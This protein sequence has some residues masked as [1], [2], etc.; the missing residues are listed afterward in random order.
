MYRITELHDEFGSYVLEAGDSRVQIMTRR[1]GLVQSFS[2]GGHEVLYCNM[3]TVEDWSKDVRGGIPILFPACGRLKEGPYGAM[4]KHGFARYLPWQ[5]TEQKCEGDS[6]IFTTQLTSNEE[7]RK[8]YPH[9]FVVSQTHILKGN[10]LSIYHTVTNT[11]EKEMPFSI[12]LHPYFNID[13]TC[14]TATVPSHFYEGLDGEN[15]FDGTFD[16]KNNYDSVCKN[17]FDREA[18]LE[19]GLGTRV[20]IKWCLPYQ[21]CVVWS[22]E[23]AEFACI[24]P[25]TAPPDALNTGCSIINILPEESAVCKVRIVLEEA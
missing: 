22:P 7:T 20:R 12:G 4:Q 11:G 1:G 24:E 3:E 13:P 15:A 9:D 5:V 23:D 17:L 18:V 19:T 25:W 8:T 10:T 21:Y 6:V 16:F 2:C 14:A